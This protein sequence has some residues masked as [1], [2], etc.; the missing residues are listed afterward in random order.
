[1]YKAM[2][3]VKSKQKHRGA[4]ECLQAAKE[5]ASSLTLPAPMPYKGHV[6]GTAVFYVSEAGS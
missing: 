6:N 4:F 1:M 5:D 3:K 2:S